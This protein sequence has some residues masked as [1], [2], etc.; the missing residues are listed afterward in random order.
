MLVEVGIEVRLHQRIVHI[1]TP[2]HEMVNRTLWTVSIVDFQSVT[3]FLEVIAHGTKTIRRTTG[4]QC[5]GLFVAINAGAHEV[6]SAVIANFE[7]GI[8]HCIR[9]IDKTFRRI[10]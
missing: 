8:R 7:N 5:G 2:S 4:K 3:Q 6:V 10:G 9:Q 1:C